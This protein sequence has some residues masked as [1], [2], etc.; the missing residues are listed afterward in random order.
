MASA[1]KYFIVA[2][3]LLR[4]K[5]W[6]WVACKSFL[7]KQTFLHFSINN[8]KKELPF[9]WLE[10][11]SLLHHWLSSFSLMSGELQARK[12]MLSVEPYMVLQ[13]HKEAKCSLWCEGA[14]STDQCSTWLL[15]RAWRPD[16]IDLGYILLHLCHPTPAPHYLQF[17]HYSAKT[18]LWHCKK[19]LKGAEIC[20]VIHTQ[21]LVQQ[22]TD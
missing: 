10:A 7:S 13:V 1:W 19:F 18:D 22:K 9:P 20:H 17:H 15:S 21:H 14:A 16:L 12:N 6:R 3:G 2:A 5:C 8:W 11:Q 4:A